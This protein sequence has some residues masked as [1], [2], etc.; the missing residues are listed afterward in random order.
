LAS[1]QFF[2]G[3]RS[4]FRIAAERA[5]ELNP[6]DG[7]TFAFLGSLIAYD[8]DWER[9]NALAARARELNPHH[10]GWYWLVAGF[11]AYRKGE[12]RP[13]LEYA[14]K[15]NMPNFWRRC[16][17]VAA[18]CAQLGEFEEAH[19]ALQDLLRMKPD[20]AEFGPRFFSRWMLPEMVEHLTDGLR[21]AGLDVP[22]G[23]KQGAT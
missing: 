19:K 16:V 12:Y 8:G 14:R 20:Y 13:A 22:E 23:Q 9:G 18:A 10:P 7:F 21:K 11:N 2:L 4:A 3:D 17:I 15:I 6:F 5:L 1:V